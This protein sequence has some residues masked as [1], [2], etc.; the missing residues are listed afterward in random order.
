MMSIKVTN[1]VTNILQILLLYTYLVLLY[2]IVIDFVTNSKSGFISTDMSSLT[3]F[4]H[5]DG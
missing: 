4:A 1:I 3:V 2:N 5:Y